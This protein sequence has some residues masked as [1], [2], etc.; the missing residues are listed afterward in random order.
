[1]SKPFYSMLLLALLIPFSCSSQKAN[2]L[3]S[4]FKKY[5]YQGK[6]ELTS[7]DLQQAR[8]GEIHPGEAVLI[9]VTEDLSK[10]KQVKL[11][12]PTASAKDAVPVLKLNMTRKFYTGI[13]PYSIMMSSFK[14]VDLKTHPSALKVTTSSQEW[15]GHTF[16]QLNKTASGF[17]AQLNSYFEKEG[18]KTFQISSGILE[19][20]IWQMIKLDPNALPTGDL[21]IIPSSIHARL[22][23]TDYRP[24]KAKATLD[25]NSG[26]KTLSTYTI[27][28]KDGHRQ[29]KIHFKKEFPHLISGWEETVQSGFGPS[30]RELTTK[31]TLKKSIMLDYWNHHDLDDAGYRAQLDL[32]SR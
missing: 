1:M 27:D 10:T 26:D 15:C 28:Y 9:F 13:Y 5:W 11:D 31:A 2:K 32:Q 4:Q 24:V 22:K 19:D 3:S 18:D 23:H 12:D 25:I 17:T 6:A 21:N 8:Y 16:F 14:P 20:E 30:A 7:Y 29:L